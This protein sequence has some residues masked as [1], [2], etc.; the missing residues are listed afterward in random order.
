MPRFERTRT[1]LLALSVSVLAGEEILAANLPNAG[2]PSKPPANIQRAS[3]AAVTR[4]VGT[5]QQARL[6]QRHEEASICEDPVFDEPGDATL[7]QTE[8]FMDLVEL[9]EP[10][11]AEYGKMEKDLEPFLDA[12]GAALAEEGLD[13]PSDRRILESLVAADGGGEDAEAESIQSL[14]SC[15][16]WVRNRN[17]S[18]ACRTSFERGPGHAAAGVFGA[19]GF[20]RENCLVN[21]SIGNLTQ[22]SRCRIHDLQ[23]NFVEE[24]NR[25]P[26]LGAPLAIGLTFES[27]WLILRDSGFDGFMRTV[28]RCHTWYQQLA[29]S[30]YWAVTIAAT[31]ASFG[32]YLT[33]LSAVV[34]TARLARIIV[35]LVAYSD[36]WS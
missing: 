32:G 10:T 33:A 3:D 21:R 27:A 4:S 8:S 28:S 7:L 9:E 22:A 34:G 5:L 30:A 23:V 17:D 18:S 29:F 20:F 6:P 16:A 26:A 36:C 13:V 31:F 15:P 24:T 11:D 1:L 2:T 14:D 19:L 35:D 25:N 12:V